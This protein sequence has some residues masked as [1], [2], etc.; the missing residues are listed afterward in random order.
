MLCATAWRRVTVS[1]ATAT[2]PTQSQTGTGLRRAG[3]AEAC[4]DVTRLPSLGAGPGRQAGTVAQAITD[5]SGGWRPG[6]HRPG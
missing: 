3:C 1:T 4:G 2:G 6:R 5:P